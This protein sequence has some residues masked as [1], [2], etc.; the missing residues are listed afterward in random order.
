LDNDKHCSKA[1]KD[2]LYKIHR[3]LFQFFENLKHLK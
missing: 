1:E 2:F 3:Q